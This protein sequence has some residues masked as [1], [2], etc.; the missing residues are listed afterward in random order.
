MKA[1]VVV[2][3]MFGN[4]RA[5]A[6]AVGVGL[7]SQDGLDVVVLDVASARLAMDGVDLVVA[8]RAA[9]LVTR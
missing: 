1:V 7:S 6:E 2:E 8:G 3:S 4:S 9:H 5:V